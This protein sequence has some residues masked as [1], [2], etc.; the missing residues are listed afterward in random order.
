[1]EDG[2]SFYK[3]KK[4][5]DMKGTCRSLTVMVAAL[6]MVLTAGVGNAALVVHFE[7]EGDLS[8]SAGGPGGTIVGAD[9]AV[10]SSDGVVG[11]G[12]LEITAE[13]SYVDTGVNPTITDTWTYAAWIKTTTDQFGCVVGDNNDDLEGGAQFILEVPDDLLLGEVGFVGAGSEVGGLT[14]A[15][16]NWHH[17][18][19]TVDGGDSVIY[20]DGNEVANN[21]GALSGGAFD[22]DATGVVFIGYGSW[23]AG[24]EDN[25]Y[26][27]L[28][29]DVRV[30]DNALTAGEV[31][32]LMDV[33]PPPPP[34]DDGDGLAQVVDMDGV[35]IGDGLEE[36][37]GTCDTEACCDTN[38]GAG[39]M[40]AADW[41]A[42]GVNDG[43]EFALGFDPKDG[44]S[45][46]PISP[47]MGFVGLGVLSLSVLAGGAVLVRR[48][49]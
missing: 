46:P 10:I 12:S 34:D 23:T 48:K 21:P 44:G 45:K 47:V 43:L 49:K 26:V 31:S 24:V 6:A 27:G 40:S 19:W 38:A 32:A 8:D 30:Y 33:G 18:A 20:L 35:P 39:C 2:V 3:G 13:G 5:D 36:D 15:D 1:V 29:D 41:D 16:G 4:E 11:S 9:A 25:F 42:D 17:I 7:F 14:I 28:V 22:L 37:T